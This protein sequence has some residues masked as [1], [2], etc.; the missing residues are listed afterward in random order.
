MP[1]DKKTIYYWSELLMYPNRPVPA[2]DAEESNFTFNPVYLFKIYTFT[3]SNNLNIMTKI[4]KL[5]LFT[6]LFPLFLN[7]QS[8]YKPGYVITLKG[9]TLHGY[10]NYKEWA[11]SPVSI[12]FRIAANNVETKQ[13]TADDISY[14]QVL[15]SEA[16]KRYSG[17]ISMDETNIAR[18]SH[19]KDMAIKTDVVF[20]KIEQDGQFITLLSY[21]DDIKKR[22]FV[23]DKPANQ[24]YELSYRSYY[25]ASHNSNVVDE[26]KFKGQLIYLN[27]K[28]NNN[29]AGVTSFIERANYDQDLITVAKRINHTV[30]EALSHKNAAITYHIGLG[31]GRN[32]IRPPSTNHG[33]IVTNVTPTY[34]YLPKLTLGLDAYTNSDVG[35]FY[36]RA[37]VALSANN[38]KTFFNEYFYSTNRS[39]VSA[40]QYTLSIYPQVVYNVYNTTPLKVYIDAGLS[41]N[42]S[43]YHSDYAGANGITSASYVPFTKTWFTIP[44]SAGVVLNDK[45]GIF[46]SYSLPT[47]VS[48]DDY[49]YY[50]TE[51]GFNYIFGH[52]K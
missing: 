22:Y 20:L 36:F 37:D 45:V 13:Y 8:N 3:A 39:F 5:I 38:F 18:L 43:K 52:R 9:D 41:A 4:Y 46:V 24:I 27:S 15:Q 12:S 40:K 35:R 30:K 11:N 19:G 21:T 16:Y 44:L 34:S 49:K 33:I 26:T 2:I 17:D 23:A 42:F 10:I 47:N 14:F 50:S 1:P 32:S 48:A 25:D 6:L 29:D 51:L 7:A 31:T 28:Y